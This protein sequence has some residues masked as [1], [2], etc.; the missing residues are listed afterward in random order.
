VAKAASR[1]GQTATGLVKGKL[2]Y[3]APEQARND[4]A[5]DRRCDVWAAGIVAW[6]LATRR[7]LYGDET[8]EMT[9]LLELV[10]KAPPRV[11]RA[12]ARAARGARRRDRLGPHHRGRRAL[13]LGA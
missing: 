4:K 12:L 11:T 5:L 3:M 10:S 6:E 2:R 8:N 13:P 7:R 9:I 1:L